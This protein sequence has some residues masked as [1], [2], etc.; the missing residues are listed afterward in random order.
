[1][2]PL[3][4]KATLDPNSLKNFRPVSN[5]PFISKILEKVVLEQLNDHKLE[6][7]LN[8]KFQSAYR[9]CHSTE[10][11]LLRI[12]ND[13]LQSMDQK[14]CCFLVLLDLSAAFDTVNHNILLNR[15]SDRFGIKDDAL[16]W[17]SSYFNRRSHFVTINGSRST[18]VFQHC[19][20]PQG[21]VLGPTFFSDY[22]S[23]LASI[24]AKW[25]VSFHSYADDTQIYASFTPGVDEELV[26]AR[27]SN[28]IREVRIWMA[29]NFLKLNDEK[30]DFIIIGN[31]YFMP[32]VQCK[33]LT[34]GEQCVPTSTSVRNIGA[35][36]DSSLTM[37]TEIKA[38]CKSAWWQLYQISKIRR[39]LTPEQVK[40]VT[41]SLVLSK[42]DQNNSL[43]H[44]LPACVLLKLQRVQNSA[45]RLLCSASRQ[46][47]AA[48]L[49]V[50][51]HWLP[52]KKRIMFKIVLLVYKCLNGIGPLYLSELLSFYSNTESRKCLR[53]SS[54]DNLHVPR[55][56]RS[57]IV[58]P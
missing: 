56:Y 57:E 31:K 44:D 42:L 50:S 48:P 2:I 10:T 54:L 22:I 40:T 5:L 49:L 28:C 27:L 46:V 11:A 41:V 36:L 30:T 53:S 43:L 38:K 32:Q 4:K 17:I 29:N 13:L 9:K 18:A 47:D 23:P 25:G 39:F 16:S 26:L 34:V 45:A 15:L 20:V 3:L 7:D 33:S 52:I 12:S 37:D 19:N 14:Q 24:F 21:S 8:E 58:Y 51:L 1:V 6:N 35:S 55:I